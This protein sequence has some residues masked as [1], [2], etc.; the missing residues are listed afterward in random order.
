[1]AR[2]YLSS[3]IIESLQQEQKA[4]SSPS[5]FSSLSLYCRLPTRKVASVVGGMRIAIVTTTIM[6]CTTCTTS[7]TRTRIGRLSWPVQ[8]TPSAQEIPIATWIYIMESVRERGRERENIE[9]DKLI[10]ESNIDCMNGVGKTPPYYCHEPT[11]SNG[12]SGQYSGTAQ[13]NRTY[14]TSYCRH[15]LVGEGWWCD[16]YDQYCKRERRVGAN[17]KRVHTGW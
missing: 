5:P 10:P 2:P 11:S 6:T 1:M 7:P 3:H 13:C 16:V 14:G 8:A 17:C 15:V 9:T 12:N 4:C